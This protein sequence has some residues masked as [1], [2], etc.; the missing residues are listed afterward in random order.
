[1][2]EYYL[3]LNAL[4][5]PKKVEITAE[6]F[7]D[8]RCAVNI[9]VESL[10]IEQKYDFV[11]ENYLEFEDSILRCGLVDMLIGGRDRKEFNANT[12]LFNRRIMNLLTAYKTYDDTHLQHFNRIFQRDRE[13]LRK[14]KSSLSQEFDG[15]VGYWMIPK[16]R[17]YVQHQGFPIHG[18]AYGS[19]W[20][21]DSHG[22]ERNRY[23]VNL[24]ISPDELS[25]GK[26]NLEIRERFARMRK[27]VD[28]KFLIRDFMEGFS[29]A[30]VRNR[31]IL[32]E[33]LEWSSEFISSVI[34]DFLLATG[35]R[36][37]VALSAFSSD[38]RLSVAH[39]ANEQ[40][41]YLV[42]KN[43]VLTRLTDRYI[44]NELESKDVDL[45]G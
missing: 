21:K 37:S 13:V 41:L 22:I 19:R 30:H 32:T 4:S 7:E 3:R 5:R 34:Q 10:Y 36:S 23:T 25:D 16:I 40:R 44:S 38:D 42:R 26:F 29:A 31:E 45:G 27:K 20:V 6:Q 43:T 1:M 39:F 17:N 24:Y 35:Y 8:I 33:R 14:A 2:S 18:S 28:L 11:M 9:Q 12:A 15:R